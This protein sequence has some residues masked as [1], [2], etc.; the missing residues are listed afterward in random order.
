MKHH[1]MI[2][3]MLIL[4]AGTA[5]TGRAAIQLSSLQNPTLQTLI[6][7]GNTPVTVGTE[8]F[9]NFDFVAGSAS[10][11]SS[12]SQVQV[13]PINNSGSG[14]QFV[15]TWF[16]SN[17]VN[18]SDVISYDVQPVSPSDSTSWI[19]LFSN[20]T[21]PAPASGTFTTTTLTTQTS[22]GASAASLLSTY[23]DGITSPIDTTKSDVN[24]STVPVLSADVL[25]IT[26]SIF[27]ASTPATSGN[28]GGLATISIVQN[29]FGSVPEPAFFGWILIPA[30]L[31][32]S[33]LMRRPRPVV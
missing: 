3:A 20:G 14:L 7:L 24:F 11:P 16:A 13:K 6:D 23:N 31:V 28:P 12:A 2:S 1:K 32:G 9:S 22:V 17:G 19:G 18:V 30:V 10:G 26:N 29:T 27:A 5:G 4:G 33:G 25:Q 21:A 15:A 8:Q